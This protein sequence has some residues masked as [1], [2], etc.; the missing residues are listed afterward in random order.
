MRQLTLSSI[1]RF[2]DPVQV[3]NIICSL[4]SSGHGCVANC[5]P[6]VMK[7]QLVLSVEGLCREGVEQLGYR[8]VPVSL[9]R[10]QLPFLEPGQQFDPRES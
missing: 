3:L 8:E 7:G 5:A 9:L 2:R 1:D 10:H 6:G 4:S